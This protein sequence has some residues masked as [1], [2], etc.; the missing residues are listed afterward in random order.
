MTDWGL[1][2]DTLPPDPMTLFALWFERAERESGLENPNAFLLSTVAADGAPDGRVLL[3]KGADESGFVFYTNKESTKGRAL[4]HETRAAMTFYWDP[5]GRQVRVRGETTDVTDEEADAYFE[6]R[7]LGSRIGAWASRQSQ[8]LDSRNA[9]EE[10][11]RA[12]E[13]RFAG[14]TVPRPAHW[15]G[16]RL[17]PSSIEFWQAGPFRLHDRMRYDRVADGW[18]ITRL[19]P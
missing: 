14:E 10:A 8:P 16:Y 6:S 1:G 2:E 15:G 7:P 4:R 9:L 19:Y 3:L 18:R 17:V 11:V 13:E 12:A 5:L